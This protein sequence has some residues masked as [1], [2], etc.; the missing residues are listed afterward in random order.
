MAKNLALIIL[1]I[2]AGGAGFVAWQQYQSAQ[3]LEYDLKKAQ[4]ML[5]KKQSDL[6]DRTSALKTLESNQKQQEEMSSALVDQLKGSIA[7]QAEVIADLEAEL[8]PMEDLVKSLTSEMGGL[9]NLKSD[10][11][12]EVES[13]NE[14]L[15]SKDIKMEMLQEQLDSV[16]ASFADLQAEF[17]QLT[18][19]GVSRLM[20]DDKEPEPEPDI[21]NDLPTLPIVVEDQAAG[22]MGANRRITVKNNSTSD[23]MVKATFTHPFEGESKTVNIPLPAG[24]KSRLD[25]SGVWVFKPGDTIRFKHPDHQDFVYTIK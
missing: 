8:Q 18:R 23:L 19:A 11:E 17:E 25:T 20:G 3:D 2:L 13:L 7:S 1:V 4:T 16:S 21:R 6:D 14:D 5:D 9:E 10:L 12:K 15:L 24:D 22:F